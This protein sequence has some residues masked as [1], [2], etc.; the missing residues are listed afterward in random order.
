MLDY[1]TEISWIRIFNI[2]FKKKVL[3]SQNL[4]VKLFFI[5]TN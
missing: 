4:K 3:I 2:L 5:D 1:N